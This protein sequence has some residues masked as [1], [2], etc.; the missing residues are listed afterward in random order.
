MADNEK[1]SKVRNQDKGASCSQVNK[2]PDTSCVVVVQ[3]LI[4]Q[5]KLLIDLLQHHQ[6]PILNPSQMQPQVQFEAD[7]AP[8]SPDN[9]PL[10]SQQAHCA[11]PHVDSKEA[12]IICLIYDEQGHYAR[13][14]PQQKRKA[15][16]RTDDEVRKMTITGTEWPPPGM[17]KRQ[18]GNFFR[19]A[20]QLTQHL[21]AN[22]GRVSDSED[23]DQVSSGDEDEK[24]P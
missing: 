24:S 19:G 9:V 23:S 15:P 12:I 22:G 14:C 8:T 20:P 21:L 1:G 2:A 7:Q 18:I 16:M 6:T 5:N 13:N 17:T 3:H 11:M 4:N 10:A